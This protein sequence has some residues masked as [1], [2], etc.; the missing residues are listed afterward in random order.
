MYSSG[1]GMYG[2][3]GGHM[4]ESIYGG[5]KS[6]YN[7]PMG[8]GGGYGDGR[9]G[10]GGYNDGYGTSGA[11]IRRSRSIHAKFGAG[12][13][14]GGPGGGAGG[15]MSRRNPYDYLPDEPGVVG[16]G[17]TGAKPDIMQTSVDQS[18][19]TRLVGGGGGGGGVGPGVGGGKPP[20]ASPRYG[21]TADGY[22]ADDGVYG[23]ARGKG[24]KGKVGR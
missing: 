17:V 18:G 9:Y 2:K 1:R 10:G 12:G 20:G 22:G 4:G 8:G 16:P 23:T 24:G 5:T 7:Q 15:G 13:G 19:G 6:M 11:N 3:R 21:N 14:P